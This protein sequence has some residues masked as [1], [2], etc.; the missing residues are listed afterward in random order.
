MKSTAAYGGLQRRLGAL[1]KGGVIAGEGVRGG[2]APY[3]NFSVREKN[4]FL[5]ENVRPNKQNLGLKIP[6]LAKYWSK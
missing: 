1:I 6:K 2:T 5:S 3:L 4:E